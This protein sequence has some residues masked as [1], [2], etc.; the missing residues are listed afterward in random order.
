MDARQR[1][2]PSFSKQLSDS[3]YIPPEFSGVVQ[4]FIEDQLGPILSKMGPKKGEDLMS[5]ILSANDRSRTSNI[6][7]ALKEFTKK[8]GGDTELFGRFDEMLVSMINSVGKRLGKPLQISILEERV[9]EKGR[10]E[11]MEMN[12]DLQLVLPTT[13]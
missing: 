10:D 1:E 2:I 5:A 12:E 7:K 11:K 6:D 9:N 8:Y 3:A 4:T 13:L